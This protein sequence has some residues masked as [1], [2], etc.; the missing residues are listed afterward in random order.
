MI[1]ALKVMGDYVQDKT[2]SSFLS[3]VVENP[4]SNGKYNTVLVVLFNNDAELKYQEIQM[5]EFTKK[6]LD[7]YAYVYGNPRGGDLTPTSKITKLESTYSRIQRP[8]KKL[9]NKIKKQDELNQEEET[10]IE[11]FNL[12]Q[13]EELKDKIYQELEVISYDDNAVLTIALQENDQIK[14]VGDFNKFTESLLDNYEKG[15]YF[16]K[17]YNKA[18]KNSVGKNNKCYICS[19]EKDKTYGYV[20]TFAF[21]TLDKP[22][23][24]TGG[25]NRGESWKNYPVCSDCARTLD[26]GKKYLEENLSS[27][28]SGIN[29]FIIPKTIFASETETEEMFEI[30]GDLEDKKKLSLEKEN[31][32]SLSGSQNDLFQMMSEFKNYVNFNIM[33]YEEINSAFRILLYVE[34]VLPSYIQKIFAAKDKIDKD[35]LFVNLQGKDGPFKLSFTFNTISNFFYVNQRGKQD[36]TKF[37]LEITN[38]IFSE[39]KVSYDLLINRFIYHIREKF[40]NSQS[41]WLDNLKALQILKF[42]NKLDLLNQNGK[43]EKSMPTVDSEY[44]KNIVD[45]LDEHNDVLNSNSKKLVFLEGVLAQKLLNIQSSER[46]GSNPFR[47]RLNGLKLNEKIIKRLYTEIINKLEEYDKNYYKQLEELIADYILESNL[48]EISNNEISF[49]FV[50]GMNQANKFN[51]QK[52]EEE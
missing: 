47:A 48:S 3:Q 18:E 36:F 13:D 38:N 4:N 19:K 15:F 29:Y 22:G 10:I 40:I 25:F 24:T 30:L 17:S 46:D 11:I 31:K 8:L 42:L 1:H 14:Y 9:V 51:F 5:E 27:R 41:Y 16:K 52:S 50:T 44:K 39:K 43:E 2:E 21:Y 33:F 23:F 37:F 32:K 49:Y 7:K 45:F 28:F 6:K 26:L 35:E 20:G 34:D 12:F